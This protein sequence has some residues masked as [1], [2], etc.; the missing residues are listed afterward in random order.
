MPSTLRHELDRLGFDWDNG[1][2]LRQDG[3]GWQQPRNCRTVEPTDPVL[4]QPWSNGAAFLD[5]PRFIAADALAVYLPFKDN[6]K[7]GLTK[8]Y[9]EPVEY[10]ERGEPI[11]Y[12]E[13]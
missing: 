12:P 6:Q 3:V 9:H 2:M 4:D 7:S 5:M 10:L 8:I 11:P 1:Q 13:V